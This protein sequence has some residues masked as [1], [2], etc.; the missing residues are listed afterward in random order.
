MK[1]L[2]ISGSLRAGSHN[3]RLLEEAARLLPEGAEL[4][5]LDGSL[6]SNVPAYDEDLRGAGPEP[7]V[8][9]ELRRR[10]AAADAVLFA[11]PEYNSSIPG[12]LKNALDWVSRP[13]ADSPLKGKDVAVVGSST[14]MFGAVWAQAELRK[15]LGALGARVVDRELPLTLADD[16]WLEDGSLGSDDQREALAE[17]V[18]ALLAAVRESEELAPA[19]AA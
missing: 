16:S 1:I 13:L 5:L 11:T 19:R 3:A 6:L 12:F 8:V 4:E 18:G 17:H 9:R 7:I 10:L 2:G 15:V 14:G